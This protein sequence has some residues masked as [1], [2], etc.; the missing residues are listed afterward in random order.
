MDEPL[1]VSPKVV[2]TSMEDDV[3][4]ALQ[5]I[6]KETITFKTGARYTLAAEALNLDLQKRKRHW[7]GEE[8]LLLDDAARPFET[9]LLDAFSCACR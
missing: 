3:I 5:A 7:T 1:H 2:E 4:G 8:G 6:C 9:S